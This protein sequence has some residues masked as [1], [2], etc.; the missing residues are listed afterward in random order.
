MGLTG[1]MG[2]RGDAGPQGLP[3]QN[4]IPGEDG[5][6]GERGEHDDKFRVCP[7]TYS[8]QARPVHRVSQVLT[9]RM[10]KMANMAKMVNPVVLA[11]LDHP[12]PVVLLAPQERLLTYY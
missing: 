10:V 3:G 9:A 11:V 5:R 12:V 4:G 1:E 6:K 7:S 2:A 8:I